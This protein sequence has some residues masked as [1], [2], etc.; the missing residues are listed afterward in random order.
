MKTTLVVIQNDSDHEEA[1]ALVEGLM[2]SN[3]AA[4]QARMTAQARA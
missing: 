1:K 4:D 2:R 3:D